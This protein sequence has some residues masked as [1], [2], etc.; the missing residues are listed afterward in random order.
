MEK[1]IQFLKQYGILIGIGLVGCGVLS[2][3]VYGEVKAENPVVEIIK[4]GQ[5]SSDHSPRI[6]QGSELRA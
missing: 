1:I 2:Y 6:T 3:G 4:S 5:Q